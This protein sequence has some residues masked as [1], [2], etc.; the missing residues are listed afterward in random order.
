MKKVSMLLVLMI[1]I[2]S[3]P[4]LAANEKKKG[5]FGQFRQERKE[6]KEAVKA[7]PKDQQAAA[8]QEQR[9]KQFDA[10][11]A[12]IQAQHALQM[13]ALDAKLNANAKLTADQKAVIR[14]QADKQH[15]A[16]MAFRQQQ[17]DQS[18]AYVAQLASNPNM[19]NEQRRAALQSFQ[20]AQ[21]EA[22]K[23]RAQAQRSENK[24][25]R[26]SFKS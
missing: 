18:Q 26:G 7:L 6:A 19:T 1:A 12:Q 14:A 25:L 15:Q 23:N 10:G 16:N 22:V 9:R 11:K 20:K 4:A 17:F 3:V 24:D 13:K 2:S 5:W 8:I 21:A